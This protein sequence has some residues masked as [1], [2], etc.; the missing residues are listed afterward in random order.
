MEMIRVEKG[1]RDAQEAY[2]AAMWL[3]FL[4]APGRQTAPG[5]PVDLGEIGE[6]RGRTWTKLTPYSV[7]QKS[8]G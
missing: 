7:A 4:R 5:E 8:D 3:M 1:P 6:T 2:I